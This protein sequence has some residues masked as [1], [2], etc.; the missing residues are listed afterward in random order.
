M[1]GVQV[2]GMYVDPDGASLN[3][4]TH[5]ISFTTI[6]QAEINSEVTIE[7]E[8]NDC[9]YLYD[10]DSKYTHF[11]GEFLGNATPALPECE[12]PGQTFQYPGSCRQYWLCQSD[13]TVDVLDC[14]PDVYVPDA[15]TCLAEDQVQ[16]DSFCP[17][18]D[19]CN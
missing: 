18:D 13:G 2:A 15:G 1:D 12:Y 11:T 17:S 19:T 5:P 16:V 9:I 4:G 6:Q 10:S 8:G 14:C 7:W 3:Y